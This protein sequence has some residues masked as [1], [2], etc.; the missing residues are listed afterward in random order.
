MA[1]VS[2]N[3]ETD[4]RAALQS[5][6]HARYVYED[7]KGHFAKRKS[8][9]D[10]GEPTGTAGDVNVLIGGKNT[11]EWHVIG[12]QTIL[13]PARTSGGL[14]L[15]LDAENNDGI[16][17]TLGNEQPANTVI[18]N[19]AGATRGTFVVGT[20]APFFVA[21]RATI[22]DVTGLDVYMVGFRKAEAYQ[23]VIENAYDEMA[24]FNVVSGDIYTSTI[25]NN[26]SNVDTDTT[27]NWTDAT[28]KTLMV[29]CDSDGSLSQDGTVGKC[30]F[31]IDGVPPTTEAS[32]RFKFDSGEIVIP[33]FAYRHDTDVCDTL[34]ATLWESGLMFTGQTSQ[35]KLGTP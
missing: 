32:S 8:A 4:V 23:A 29:I 11:F 10:D 13:G 12:T 2:I 33:F 16:E 3:H 24:A 30:Y 25:L 7:F 1:G 31:C 34:V 17:L 22:A 28:A 19:V 6:A 15:C 5:D 9:A 14:N 18:S 26:A 27:D 20:D 35:Y 21:F